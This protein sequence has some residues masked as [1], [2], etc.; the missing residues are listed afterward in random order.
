MESAEDS[1]TQD[2]P[3]I[4]CAYPGPL[5]EIICGHS[6][7]DIER[8]LAILEA[9]LSASISYRDAQGKGTS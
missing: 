7:S 3:P 5:A 1:E 9:R 4:S 8:E 2:E 6:S